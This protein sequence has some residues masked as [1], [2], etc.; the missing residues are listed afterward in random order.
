M[1]FCVNLNLEIRLIRNKIW[2]EVSLI[3]YI[4]IL[5][6]IRIGKQTLW[7]ESNLVAINLKE[8]RMLKL[9]FVLQSCSYAIILQE[10]IRV[11]IRIASVSLAAVCSLVGGSWHFVIGIILRVIQL[12]P[13]WACISLGSLESQNVWAVSIELGNL[14]MTYS[15]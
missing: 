3:S 1:V 12:W 9:G 6:S 4:L 13:L 11:T 5:L 2:N 8:N 15:L 14:S 7:C 10:K